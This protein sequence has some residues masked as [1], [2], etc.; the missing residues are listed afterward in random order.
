MI[1]KSALLAPLLIGGGIL[2]TA[3]V[4]ATLGLSGV[5]SRPEVIDPL[6]ASSIDSR[7][8]DAFDCVG[9]AVVTSL[10]AGQRVLIVSRSAD[11]Q[12]VGV[13]NP[14]ATE[15]TVWLPVP[16]LT[17]DDSETLG[18][19]L[20]VGGV[21]PETTITLD[22]VPEE[23]EEEQPSGPTGDTGAPTID[24]LSTSSTPIGCDNN[25]PNTLATLT[26][27]A[28]DD[29]GVTAVALSWTGAYTGSGAM[30]RSGASWVFTFDAGGDG[31]NYRGDVVFTA[32]ATDAAGNS[33][34]AAS[35]TLF[36]DCV[37]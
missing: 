9:G 10:P 29:T 16:V 35:A 33:S 25:F 17:L 26:A 27:T 2:L 19:T 4:G 23:A 18:D 12:W 34:A 28:S 31:F 8:A 13:R 32:V 22:S 1:P 5:I 14:S 15:S 6:S 20:P 3:S 21:C 30:Q 37:V 36:V 24:A 7:R 11:S